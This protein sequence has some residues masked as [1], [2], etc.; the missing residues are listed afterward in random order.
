VD[1]E[2]EEDEGS[3]ADNDD[4]IAVAKDQRSIAEW[5]QDPPV[6]YLMNNMNLLCRTKTN[7]S[8]PVS[9][10]NSP[11]IAR[12]QQDITLCGPHQLS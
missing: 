9:M 2:E 8:R 1:A 12:P 3:A 4:D 7:M 5:Q 11:C 10:S 6:V